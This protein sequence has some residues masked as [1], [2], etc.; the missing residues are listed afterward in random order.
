MRYPLAARLGY[1]AL[2]VVL[3][4]LGLAWWAARL[5]AIVSLPRMGTSAL[6]WTLAVAGLALMLAAMRDLWVHGRGLPMSAFPPEH[7]VVGGAYRLVR[8][9]IYAGAVLLVAGAAVVAGSPAGLWIVTP[10]LALAVAAWVHGFERART[11][12]RFGP[13]PPAFL[14]L[15]TG[16]D[17]PLGVGQRVAALLL[18]FVPWL[19]LYQAVEYLGAPG[20]APE[21][22]L[23]G[24]RGW[25]ILPWTELVYAGT[26]PLVL[27]A[28]LLARTRG[29]LREFAIS[30][31]F[32]TAIAIA[33]YLL[34]PIVAPAKPVVGEGFWQE[35]MRWERRNDSPAT[36]FP[37]F[38]LTW[39]LLAARVYAD[40]WPKARPVT[41]TLVAAIGVSCVTTGMHA[42]LDVVG[43]GLLYLVASGRGVIWRVVRAA[44][45]HLA[46]SW[47][48]WQCGP[49]RVLSH[50]AW[51]GLAGFVG[52]G[53]TVALTGTTHLP[54]VF[55]FMAVSIA[56]AAFWAQ[57][58]E[59]SP[60]LL[61]PF[62]Y[63]GSAF[64]VMA[65]A[66]VVEAWGGTGWLLLAAFGAGA[67]AAQAVG[68]VRCLVQGCCHGRESDESV[69]IRYA[70]PRSRVVRLAGLGGVALHPTPV[71]SMGWMLLVCGI[72][73]RLWLAGVPPSFLVGVYFILAGL[74]RFVE[75]HFRG[76]PQTAEFGGLRLY[77]WLAVL[78]V[79]G[80]AVITTLPGAPVPPPPGL[81]WW[82]APVLVGAGLLTW[83]AYGVDLPGSSRRFSRL[84]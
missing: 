7:L 3:L 84:T 78:F 21:A 36:A 63:F 57:V 34:L 22:Y 17:A 1:G 79:V 5:D 52:L 20:W 53:V 64:G 14:Q 43:G 51:A 61:R 69:G 12:A 2:F 47:R 32:A 59:G 23:P 82:M 10:T 13:L 45:E 81:P 71:Y 48:E 25:P 11:I 46:N 30:G 9:P 58:V 35:L 40:R 44:A 72:V 75:E 31:L 49:V 50:G 67:A 60:Q 18:T 68:R 16:G 27:A 55:L 42:L 70:H 28:P 8:D 76:E 41:W 4:P 6:G 54:M 37:A 83:V 62:G 26:Y 15:P 73:I 77:Q 38:H 56:S 66:M 39:A 65:L 33:W 19:I 74:G 29:S 24:E 80:G